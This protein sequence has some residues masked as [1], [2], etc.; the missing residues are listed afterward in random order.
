MLQQTIAGKISSWAVRWYAVSLLHNKINLYPTDSLTN[1]IA[2]L[3]ATH[4]S[5]NV[6]PRLAKKRIL[7]LPTEQKV[8]PEVYAQMRRAYWWQQSIFKKIWTYFQLKTGYSS[9]KD[10]Y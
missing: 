5:E 8:L 9:F 7:L 1:H 10:N 4:A 6:T 2:G 3:G